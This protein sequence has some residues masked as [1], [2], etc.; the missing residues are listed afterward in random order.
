MDSILGFLSRM[1]AMLHPWLNEIAT[2]MVACLIVVFGADINRLLRRNLAGRSFTL[3]T[4]I[5]VLVNAFG[6]GILIV[7]LSPWLARKLAHMPSYW[8]LLLVVAAFLFVGA[9]AQ[10]NRQV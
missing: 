9:W 4:L 1:G 2:A 7:T 3:R 5:F 8:M 10:R 6:Y